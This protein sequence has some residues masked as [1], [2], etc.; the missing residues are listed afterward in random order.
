MIE[1]LNLTPKETARYISAILEAT[2][3]MPDDAQIAA[4][5]MLMAHLRGFDTHGLPCL[6]DYVENLEQNRI[7]PKPDIRIEKATSWS[8]R[9]DADNGLGHVAAHRAMVQVLATAEEFGVGGA[10]VRRSNHF[11]AASAYSLMALEHDCIGLVTSNASAVTAPFGAAQPLLGTNPL[12]VAVP[13]GK[14]PPFVI[15]MAT[16]E[17][18][19]KK[20]RLALQKGES[21]PPGWAMDEKGHPTT[22]PAK[23]LAG[24]M[25]PFGGVKGSAITVL[26][27]ILSG[28]LSGAKF[29][30]DVL[31]VFTNQKRESGNGN[32]FLAFKID[33][34]I[35]VET[36]KSRMDEE[37][38]RI[39][40]LRPAKGFTEVIYPG[41]KEHFIQN[42]RLQ[43]GIPLDMKLMQNLEQLGRNLGVELP[44]G[45][46]M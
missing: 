10:V 24:V 6:P 15:D 30:G 25:L 27:D 3:V 8:F 11:G 38:T 21:L 18:A 13:G 4:E 22:D 46:L 41:Y 37:L 42:E 20:V 35:P 23:A 34:F 32:F 9:M 29:G 14:L 12:S 36:F 7:N 28:V 26:L 5:C 43:K 16:S 40:S 19:L 44:L 31:S 39:R 45:K 1:K 17:G 2:G 33:A